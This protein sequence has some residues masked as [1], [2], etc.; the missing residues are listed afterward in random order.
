MHP[1]NT[2]T[3]VSDWAKTIAIVNVEFVNT[4]SKYCTSYIIV[5]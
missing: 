3:K 2:I 4:T 1:I 5:M